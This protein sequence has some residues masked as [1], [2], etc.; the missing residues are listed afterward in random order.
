[1]QTG[2]GVPSSNMGWSPSELQECWKHSEVEPHRQQ[3]AAS[4]SGLDKAGNSGAGELDN[5][6]YTNKLQTLDEEDEE[7][8]LSLVTLSQHPRQWLTPA[9]NPGS[10]KSQNSPDFC[11]CQGCVWCTYIMG[12]HLHIPTK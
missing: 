2:R 10:R 7:M 3:Q 4:S 11:R 12:R 6:R 1:V 5:E 9:Y 8:A